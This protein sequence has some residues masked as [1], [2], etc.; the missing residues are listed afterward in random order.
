MHK[1][2]DT[3]AVLPAGEL[4]VNET[5]V[6]GKS[7]FP[8]PKHKKN[9]KRILISTRKSGCSINVNIVLATKKKLTMINAVSNDRPAT[10]RSQWDGNGMINLRSVF[11]FLQMNL[12]FYSYFM[13][14]CFEPFFFSSFSSF[15]SVRSC[16]RFSMLSSHR[17]LFHTNTHSTWTI[18][19]CYLLQRYG[20]RHMY[21]TTT[22]GINP[23]LL[24]IDYYETAYGHDYERVMRKFANASKD[25]IR[26]QLKSVRTE[27]ILD[28]LAGNGAAIV[29]TNGTMLQCK[30]CGWAN[31]NQSSAD[32]RDNGNNSES[33]R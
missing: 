2:I 10:R 26:V 19:L 20:M 14:T 29:L 15:I 25:G 7:P 24:A 22:L 28:H 31:R 13:L 6:F 3:V 12:F 21:L 33:L 18:D 27:V 8:N 17:Q 32:E 1:R 9:V 16:F 4:L 30:T 11:S 5:I 23:T